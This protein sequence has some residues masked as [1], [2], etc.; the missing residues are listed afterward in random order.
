[1]VFLLIANLSLSQEW[2]KT[3]LNDFL[4]AEFPNMPEKS[5]FNGDIYYSTSDDNGAY[6][7]MI[8]N[9]RNQKIPESELPQFYQGFMNGALE[10][11]N[12]ELIEQSEFNSKGIHG[13][14]MVYLVNSD[15]ELPDLRHKRILVANNNL[16]SFEFWTYEE[17][18]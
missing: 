6:I 18:K 2:S 4:S 9:L 11:A 12:G 17:T 7:V 13:Y 16:I 1:I 8:K 15:P 3:E 5:E 14:E 10:S